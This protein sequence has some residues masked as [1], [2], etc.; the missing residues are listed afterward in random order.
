MNRKLVFSAIVPAC[1]F[2]IFLGM[3]VPDISRP[4]RPAPR[5]RA[6]V[7]SALKGAQEAGKRLSAEV[8]TL[9][10]SPRL[11]PEPAVSRSLF[12]PPAPRFATLVP[13]RPAA[14]SP[15]PHAA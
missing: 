15:P 5:P 8:A 6:V 14:R 7:E 11:A 1:L 10:V 3:K 13:I 4:A 9:P 2:L 12:S